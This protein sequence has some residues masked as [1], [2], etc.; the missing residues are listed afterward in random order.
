MNE[1]LFYGNITRQEFLDGEKNADIL[2]KKFAAKLPAWKDEAAL[3]SAANLGFVKAAQ[4]YDRTKGWRWL[5]YLYRVIHQAL[6]RE[7]M[8][9]TN[10]Q[11]FRS[12]HSRI[13]LGED[14][15]PLL[16]LDGF[17]D[18]EG[19]AVCDFIPSLERSVEEYVVNKI[20]WENCL[21][22]LSE[23][24][25]TRIQ[26]F[27][28]EVPMTERVDVTTRQNTSYQLKQAVAKIRPAYFGPVKEIPL[29][30]G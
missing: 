8:V 6:M 30:C 4:H 24:H 15:E 17:V 27:L 3:L 10:Y 29:R 2:A 21:Q 11:K 5:T 18:P 16:S 28:D 12:P 25:A 9:Q 20:H 13:G 7:W 22:S 23:L 26:E 19:N 1:P 14:F